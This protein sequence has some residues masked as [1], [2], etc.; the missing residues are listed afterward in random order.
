MTNLSIDTHRFRTGE[1]C[2]DSSGVYK[3]VCRLLNISD[4]EL[5]QRTVNYY[6]DH[7]SRHPIFVYNDN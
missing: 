2:D 6:F 1:I 7:K 3:A 4:E 5:H